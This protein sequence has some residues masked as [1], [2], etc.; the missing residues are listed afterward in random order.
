MLSV[1]PLTQSDDVL[2]SQVVNAFDQPNLSALES[3]RCVSDG[4]TVILRGEVPS[5]YLKQVATTLAIRVPGVQRV[6]NQIQVT[7]QWPRRPR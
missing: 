5:M 1:S 3:V 2:A 4:S 6:H 7:S